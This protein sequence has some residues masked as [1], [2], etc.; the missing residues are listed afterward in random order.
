MQPT[1]WLIIIVERK[2]VQW[3]RFV[4]NCKLEKIAKK[5]ELNTIIIIAHDVDNLLCERKENK[6][7]TPLPTML[8]SGFKWNK[9]TSS[10]SIY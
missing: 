6:K 3:K 5:Q 2:I 8:I 1:V 7:E 4:R 9:R 10:N